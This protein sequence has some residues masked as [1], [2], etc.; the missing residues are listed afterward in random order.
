MSER[1]DYRMHMDVL[2]GYL[3]KVDVPQLVADCQDPWWNQTL[4]EVN[5]C[6]IRLG[7]IQGEFHWHQHDEEDEFFFVVEGT[8][9]IDVRHEG[10]EE[11]T[12]ELAQHQGYTVPKG[13]VHRT[14]APEKV[15]MLMVE[16]ASVVP[17][18]D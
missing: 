2:C 17:T 3:S 14:R 10:G 9:L 6:V 4:C 16:K 8:L 7:I 5:D 11:E 18:G 13:V 1:P 15:V 12:I